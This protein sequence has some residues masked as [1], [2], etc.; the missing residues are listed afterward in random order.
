MLG[1]LKV[2]GRGEPKKKRPLSTKL[3]YTE[4]HEAPVPEVYRGRGASGNPANRFEALH[5]D[6]DPVEPSDAE[7]ERPKLPTRFYR[8]LT[9]TIISER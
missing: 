1:G 4:Y 6:L 7:A 3:A 8:D 2:D 5:I 9:K